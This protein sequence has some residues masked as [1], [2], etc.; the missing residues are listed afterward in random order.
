[1]EAIG[2]DEFMAANAIATT[3]SC[4]RRK[5]QCRE[6]RDGRGLSEDEDAVQVVALPGP[7]E[8]ARALRIDRQ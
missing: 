2:A 5:K 3:M 6:C 4:R 7:E 8:S 1:M